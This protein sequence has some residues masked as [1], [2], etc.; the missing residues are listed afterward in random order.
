V[1]LGGSD[2]ERIRSGWLAQPANAVSSLAY[3][4]VG[5]W[6][7][8]RSCAPDAGV[9]RKPL[10]AGGVGMVGVGLGSFAYH[11]PQ[12]GWAVLAHDGSVVGL[13][14][15]LVADNLSLL[16]P[17][18]LRRAVGY[19]A[20]C[21]VTGLALAGTGR[22]TLLTPALGGAVVAGAA[23]AHRRTATEKAGAAWRASAAWMAVAF[24][25]YWAGRTGSPLC[26]PATLW[27]PHA[28]WHG[29]SA[30][31]LGLAVLGCAARSHRALHPGFMRTG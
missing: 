2:C 19:A 9:R 20:P 21:A 15:V 12:P 22:T 25:A 1:V 27:Q 5:A 30:V 10:F 6:L 26:H 11:G 31:G 14:L 17:V 8:W 16:A 4:A 18:S 13:A 3:V 23:L 7:L 28:A 24:G 29:L